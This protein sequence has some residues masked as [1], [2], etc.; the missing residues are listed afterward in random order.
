[1]NAVNA[2]DTAFVL[3]C[4]GLVMLMRFVDLFWQVTPAILT[5][6]LREEKHAVAD[7]DWRWL[8]LD[9]AALVALSGAWLAWFIRQLKRMPLLPIGDP[10]LP[11]VTTHHE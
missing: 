8:W 6:A 9:L 3:I 11:E 1:M 2:G 4:A 5:P 10:F 7:L